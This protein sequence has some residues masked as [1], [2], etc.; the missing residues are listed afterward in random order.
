VS[1]ART[2]V[3]PPVRE[4]RPTPIQ[5]VVIA[6]STGGPEAL[7]KVFANI[8]RTFPVPIIVVQHMPPV[9]TTQLAERL[10]AISG[11][12]VRE[13]T[14]EIELKPGTVVVAPG[15][16]HVV[17]RRKGAITLVASPDRGPHENSCRPAADV[18][19]RSAA[20][21]A[22]GGVVVAVLTGIGRDGCAGARAVVESG[23]RVLAQDQ[24]S[25]VVWGMPGSVV[26]EKLADRVLPLSDMAAGIVSMVTRSNRGAAA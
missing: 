12:D 10:A 26:A 13:G 15:D 25:S 23:G 21:A 9:F 11:L 18:T 20:I 3:S 24:A 2:S 8:P 22:P 5:L 17:V 6:S 4:R 19:L 7:A 1:D 16:H 14:T